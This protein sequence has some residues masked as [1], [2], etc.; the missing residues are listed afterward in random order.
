MVGR[1]KALWENYRGVVL[2]LF[3]KVPGLPKDT[4]AYLAAVEEIYK[5]DAYHSLSIESYPPLSGW[6]RETEA[7]ELTRI[8]NTLH[9]RHSEPTQEPLA[10][11][12]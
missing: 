8:G 5:Y 4:K 2:E 6:Q 9:I 11:A 3:P 10:S 7:C 12:L 1:I